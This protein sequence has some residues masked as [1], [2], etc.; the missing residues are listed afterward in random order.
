MAYQLKI[1]PSATRRLARLKKKDRTHITQKI[2][3]L[4]ENPRPPGVKKLRGLANRWCIRAGDYRVIYDIQDE[5]L[6]VIVIRVGDR[7]D[8]YRRL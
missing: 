7:R 2:S 5:I 3:A 4:A 8:S 6:L 1:L